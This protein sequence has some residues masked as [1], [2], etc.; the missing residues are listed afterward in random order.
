MSKYHIETPV[1]AKTILVGLYELSKGNLNS[2]YDINPIV[3]RCF[4]PFAPPPTSNINEFTDYLLENKWIRQNKTQ[5]EMTIAITL[6][7]CQA[8]REFIPTL[9]KYRVGPFF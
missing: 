9:D 2:F 7:G 1:K 8:A 4:E 6:E 5:D 3:K